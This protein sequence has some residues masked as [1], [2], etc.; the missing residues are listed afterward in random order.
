V[1]SRRVVITGLAPISPIGMGV[2]DFWNALLEQGSAIRRIQS[3]DPSRFESQIGGEIDGLKIGNYV[4]K[5]YRK[6]GKIMARDIV[7]AMAAAHQAVSDAGI[8]TKWPRNVTST[9]PA[10]EPTLAPA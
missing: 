10:W 2:T 4:P 3:F 7:L 5:G 8:N 9:A 6:A 1:S